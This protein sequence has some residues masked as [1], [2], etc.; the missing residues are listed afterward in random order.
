[1]ECGLRRLRETHELG[2]TLS[3]VDYPFWAPLA[4]KLNNNVVL[5]D[6]MDN[7]TSFANAGRPARELEAEIAREADLVVCSSAH[8]QQRIGRE[9]ALIRNG[10]D[11]AHFETPPRALALEPNGRTAGYWGEIGD[12][13][14]V[15]LL[16]FAARS[17]PDVRFVLIGEPRVEVSALA[18]L[19][20]VTLTGRVPYERLPEYAHTFDVCLLPYR[21]CDYALAS[22]PLKVWEYLSAGKPVVAVRFAEIERLG[23]LVTLTSTPEEFVAAI[24]AALEGDSPELAERRKAYARENT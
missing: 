14:D 6:C 19:P 9:S 17:L 8:L 22:D 5:Y 21:I 4:R 7:Y 1:M 16:V 20:N 24:R 13:T 23:E 11:P 15:E 2:A 3:I 12:W 18:A 10:V